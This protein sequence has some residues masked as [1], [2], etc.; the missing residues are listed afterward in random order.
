MT[1]TAHDATRD[2][3]PSRVNNSR[4]DESPSHATDHATDSRAVGKSRLS[5]AYSVARVHDMVRPGR[6]WRRAYLSHVA[7]MKTKGETQHGKVA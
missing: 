6:I 2:R 5:V 7:W 4:R 3:Y 1:V